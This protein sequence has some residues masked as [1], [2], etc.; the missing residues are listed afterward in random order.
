MATIDI[1]RLAERRLDQLSSE[2]QKPFR[3]QFRDAYI[4]GSDFASFDADDDWVATQ[5]GGAGTAD[6]VDGVGGMLQ[7]DSAS[8]SA[9]QGI[10]VQHKTETILPATDKDIIF[11]CRFK[12]TDTSATAQIFAGLSV[13][14]TSLFAS[15]LNSS[16][17]HI[18]FEAD[19]N[20]I[21]AAAESLNF[22]TEKGG[23]RGEVAAA[24]TMV[25]DTFFIVGFYVDSLNSVTPLVNGLAGTP[26]ETGSTTL[27]VTEL[28]ASFLCQSEG[29]S[30]PIM[31]LDWYYTI[32][33]R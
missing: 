31:L 33:V 5:A 18:G 22:A 10:Q 16:T 28:A 12:I 15:G 14:D 21:A 29:S 8:S 9:D 1:Q 7:L 17:N 11:E 3:K 19:F 20:D 24:H 26:V 32:Q 23:V 30:D 13:L 27:P 2:M 4:E 6:V 25:E